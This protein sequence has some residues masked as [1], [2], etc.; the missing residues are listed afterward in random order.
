M[1]AVVFHEHGDVDRLQWA[2]W[3]DPQPGRGEVLVKIHACA[4]NHLDIWVR[5]GGRPAPIPMPH[6]SG[7]DI[8]GTVAGM[9][10]EVEGLETGMRVIVAPGLAPEGGEFVLT[11]RDSGDPAFQIIGFQTQGGYAEYITVPARNIIP[12]SDRYSY[13][14]WAS[15]PLVFLTAWHM[16]FARLGLRCGETI[17][18]QAAGS[19]LGIA[20]IQLAKLAGA[21]V[22][23]TAGSE[24]KLHRARELGADETINYLTQDFVKET[25][26]LT[27]NQ[28]V[29]AVFEHVGGETFTRSLDALKRYGRLANCGVTAGAEVTI[30]LQQVFA[31]HLTIHGS[32][33]GSIG[34]LKKVIALAEAGKVKPVIDQIFPLKEARAA[35]QRM[36]DRKNFGKIVLKVV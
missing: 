29:D 26:R 6:I 15:M 21:R 35:Q 18:V 2:E 36:L 1:K 22:I 13:E 16:L 3:P 14:E 12:V 25:L 4:L 27:N 8:A 32:Y 33:M 31:K 9:G 10:P 19:G 23:T 5:L 11:D 17:L 20:A 34:E 28:G 24:E 30:N 7:S